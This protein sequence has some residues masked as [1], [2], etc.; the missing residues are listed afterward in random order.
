MIEVSYMAKDKFIIIEAN[1]IS[2]DNNNIL[3]WSFSNTVSS[4]KQIDIV[5]IVGASG[6]PYRLDNILAKINRKKNN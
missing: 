6:Q 3:V 5:S 4:I 1:K 2:I